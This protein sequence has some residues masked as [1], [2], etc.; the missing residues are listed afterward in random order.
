MQDALPSQLPGHDEIPTHPEE[1]RT[2]FNL[3]IGRSVSL[4][5]SARITPAG[6][7]TAGLTFCAILVAYGHLARAMPRRRG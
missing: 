4:Q 7:V 3:R 6:V 1:M 5:G 2:S